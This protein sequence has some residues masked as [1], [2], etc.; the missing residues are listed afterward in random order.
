VT[1]AD[2]VDS[3]SMLHTL[4][5]LPVARHS[6]CSSRKWETAGPE[7]EGVVLIS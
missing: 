5:P 6:W 2:G 4:T 7:G 1:V 3:G